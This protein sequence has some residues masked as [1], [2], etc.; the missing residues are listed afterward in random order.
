MQEYFDEM[1]DDENFTIIDALK[2]KSEVF[3]EILGK[4]DEKKENL[5]GN[6]AKLWMEKRV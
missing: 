5:G 1:A 4:I 2:T 3:A 6:I